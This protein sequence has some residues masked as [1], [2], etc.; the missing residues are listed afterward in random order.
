MYYFS[1]R[2]G[3]I[4][5]EECRKKAEDA[6]RMNESTVYTMQYVIVSDIARLYSFAVSEQVLEELQKVLMQYA[7]LYI[8]H[9]FKSLKVLEEIE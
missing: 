3:G 7:K 2:K 5:C 8:N 4:L 9:T 1:L 6:W